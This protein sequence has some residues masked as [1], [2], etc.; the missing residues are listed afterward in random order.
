MKDLSKRGLD[1]IEKKKVWRLWRSGKT[2]SEIGLTVYRHAGSIF[3]VLKANGGISPVQRK[4]RYSFLTLQDRE[5]ISRGLA[6]GDSVTG[7]ARLIMKSPST[8]SREINRNGGSVKYC[9]IAADK[10]ALKKA[11]RPKS[12]K[13][14]KSRPISKLVEAKLLDDWSP[15][16]ISGWLKRT[17]NKSPEMQ[18]SHETIYKILFT[19]C[20]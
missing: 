5:S 15:E 1:Y 8:V 9:A 6:S 12:Y 19:P 20:R 4:R 3:G 18:V 10:H 14:Q 7:I 2:L 16:Q 13:L 17:H 11:L